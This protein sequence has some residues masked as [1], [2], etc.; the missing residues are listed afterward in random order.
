[1]T[2]Q[3]ITTAI[4]RSVH[5]LGLTLRKHSPEILAIG[6]AIGVVAS[7][8]LACRAT[9]KVGE[10]L[11]ETKEMLNII[12]EGIET[13]E[14]NGKEFTEDDCK[15]ARL[16]VYGQ[17]GLKF[18]KLYGPSVALGALSLGSLLTSNHILRQ[19]NVALAAAYAAVEKSLK[20]YRNRVVER[21]GEKIDRELLYGIKTKTV[22]ET[23]KDEETGEEKVIEKTVEVSDGLCS[24]YARL[25]DECNE[26]WEKNADFNMM[27]LR[28]RQSWANDLLRANGH[29][30][31]N[32]VYEMLGFPKSKAGQIVGWIYDPKNPNH[33]GNNYVDFGINRNIDQAKANFIN[34][35]ERSI[36]LDFNVD[37][38]ILKL[39]ETKEYRDKFANT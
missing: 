34:G 13:G 1:M 26:N 8:I 27:F 16:A 25:F 35:Y 32:D 31:L 17:T 10:I 37:G 21:F 3:A 20:T 4:S 19:R 12:D 30:F 24:P 2:T 23:V 14:I 7:G 33:N 38:D 39:M 28:A 18:V 6:G 9:T 29:L 15:K 5:R 11:N 22:T 36:W